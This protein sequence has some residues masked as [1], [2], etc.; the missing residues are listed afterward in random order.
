MILDV[1]THA[2]ATAFMLF[3]LLDFRFGFIFILLRLYSSIPFWDLVLGISVIGV[4]WAIV[5][6]SIRSSFGSSK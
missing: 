3:S 4:I 1:L 5:T 6:L 2:D